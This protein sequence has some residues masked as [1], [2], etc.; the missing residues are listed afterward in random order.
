MPVPLHRGPPRLPEEHS[1]ARRAGRGR[2]QKEATGGHFKLGK[3][4]MPLNSTLFTEPERDTAQTQQKHLLCADRSGHTHGHALILSLHQ[5]NGVSI[6]PSLKR[7]AETEA[8]GDSIPYRA[9]I[10][11]DRNS[12]Q[13]HLP[14]CDRLLSPHFTEEGPREGE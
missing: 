1:W 10:V 4:H 5:H 7:D 8:S 12:S 13:L 14:R 9:H 6:T 3:E 11:A 2:G